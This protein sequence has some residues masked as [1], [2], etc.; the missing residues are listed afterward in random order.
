MK[1][2]IAVCT[3]NEGH[4]IHD[5]LKLLVKVRNENFGRN[6]D[7]YEIVIVDDNSTDQTTLDAFQKFASDITVVKHS[8]NGDFAIHKNFMNSVCSGD[9]ILNLDADETISAAFLDAIPLY[10]EANPDI[11][12]Y[13]LPRVNTVNG[14]TLPHVQKWGWVL[15]TLP[16]F[17]KAKVLDPTSPEYDLLKQYG[18]IIREENGFVT[19]HQPIIQWPD[20]QMRLYRNESH[21]KWQGAVHERLI[22]FVNFSAF[23]F[24]PEFAIQHHKEIE[25]QD[26][27][28]SFYETIT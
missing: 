22:G 20:P 8:L 11:D 9:W 23:P 24:T 5:L 26:A 13:W 18:F 17:T 14:L 10:I 2:S 21:I 25:R 3:H 12:A 1:L 7:E 28:N 15:E 19:Y 27:Q 16:E 4:Y 6:H